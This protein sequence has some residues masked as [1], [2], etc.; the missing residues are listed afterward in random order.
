MDKQHVLCWHLV[1]SRVTAVMQ[2]LLGSQWGKVGLAQG[3]QGESSCRGGWLQAAV[4][5]WKQLCEQ[6]LC[7]CSN[8][9]QCSSS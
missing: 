1:F 2:G 7:R 3:R 5:S 9:L 4:L 8:A 6:H